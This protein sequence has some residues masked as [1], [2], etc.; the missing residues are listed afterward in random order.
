M[1]EEPLSTLSPEVLRYP[2]DDQ[3]LRRLSLI[4]E[5]GGK[6]IRMAHLASVGSHAIN[7]VAA[8]HT[9]LLKQTVLSDFYRVAPEK[10]F[11]VTNGVTPHRW[12]PLS[13]PNRSALITRKIGDRWLSD[14]E[15]ELEH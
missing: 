9:E 12:I 13:N 14:L 2:S 5:T 6:Y 4:D 1:P 3:L 8:L 15:K 10:F 11:N 7:G